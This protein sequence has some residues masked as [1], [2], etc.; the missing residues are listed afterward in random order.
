M[1]IEVLFPM[2][3]HGVRWWHYV[4]RGGTMGMVVVRQLPCALW[5]WP[6]LRPYSVKPEGHCG[7]DAGVGDRPGLT[8]SPP[9]RGCVDLNLRQV[10]ILG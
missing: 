4:G 1:V 7:I 3:R 5:A 8:V 2:A 10:T 6:G 9:Y